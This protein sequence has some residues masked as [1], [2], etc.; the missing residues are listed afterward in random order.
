[1]SSKPA[2]KKRRITPKA[3]YGTISAGAMASSVNKKVAVLQKQVRGLQRSEELKSLDTALAFNV[4]ATGEIPATGQL[5]L[6]PQGAADGQRIG[7]KVSVKSFQIRAS[8]GF[9][10]A[11]AATASSTAHIF[12][13]Q[14]RQCN[15]AAA[16]VLDVFSSTNLAIAMRD[17][18][19]DSRFRILHHWY[20]T[21]TPSAGVTTAYNNDQC[22]WQHYQK[23]NFPLEFSGA[24]GAIGEIAT[25]N[26]FLMA[27]TEGASDDAIQVAGIARVTFTDGGS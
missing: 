3:G 10:P 26:I 7:R 21:F 12:V 9:V 19:N 2:Y 8:V 25:N 13:I 17:R 6:I 5:C 27:S 11:A 23:V 22:A 16:A 1:M 14:D 18:V 4:D 20:H 24:A 15:G